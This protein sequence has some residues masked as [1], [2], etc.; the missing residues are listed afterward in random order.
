V[1]G[2]IAG[3][4]PPGEVR[5]TLQRRA[6][7]A[8]ILFVTAATLFSLITQAQALGGM[9]A[10]LAAPLGLSPLELLGA[11]TPHALPELFAVFLPLAAWSIAS[12]RGAWGDLLA[13]TIATTAIAVPLI[14][15]A[16]AVETWVTPR[17]LIALIG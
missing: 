1:A 15:A 11:L 7:P 16:A 12:R 13:A 4:T 8:A 3:W 14:V 2:F 10:D 17:L 9:T 5:T 6:A